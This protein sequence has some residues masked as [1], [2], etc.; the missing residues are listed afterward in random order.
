[1][2]G[3]PAARPGAAGRSSARAEVRTTLRANRSFIGRV[4]R[5]LVAEAGIEQFVD[6]GAGLPTRENVHQVAQAVNP[7][8]RVV[9][10]DNDPY[11]SRAR[12]E[13]FFDEFDLVDPGLVRLP[14][15]HPVSEE[16]AGAES[17]GSEWMLG[18]VGRR[19]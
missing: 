2:A 19:R 3:P 5:Y 13:R 12:I 15:W 17:E 10:V 1:V 7:K 4:V 18:G 6:L 8:A 14:R 11:R 9:Y 16:A